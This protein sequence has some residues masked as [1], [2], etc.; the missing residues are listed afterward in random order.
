MSDF[1][2]DPVAIVA[3]ETDAERAQRDALEMIRRGFAPPAA[4]VEAP[5]EVMDPGPQPPPAQA[6]QAAQL[7]SAYRAGTLPNVAQP[8]SGQVVRGPDGREQGRIYPPGQLPPPHR[9]SEASINQR[10]GFPPPAAGSAPPP[11]AA[12]GASPRPMASTRAQRLASL[13]PDDMTDDE[14]REAGVA[15]DLGAAAQRLHGLAPRIQAAMRPAPP[16]PSLDAQTAMRTAAPPQP[17]QPSIGAAAARLEELGPRIQD[18]MPPPAAPLDGKTPSPDNAAKLQ[19]ILGGPKPAGN[20]APNYTGVD[21]VDGLRSA[22]HVI[23]SMLRGLSGNDPLPAPDSLGQQARERDS[24]TQLQKTQQGQQDARG[25]AEQREM[26]LRERAQAALE[27]D[28]SQRAQRLEQDSQTRNEIQQQR[29]AID[30]DLAEGRIDEMQ[31]RSAHQALNTQIL[32]DRYDPASEASGRARQAVEQQVELRGQARR[33]EDLNP[34]R[35]DGL[36][37]VE[38]ERVGQGVNSITTPRLPGR[39]GAGGGGGGGGRSVPQ[40]LV[41][42]PQGWTGTPEAWAALP[43]RERGRI[44][45]RLG[46]RPPDD[47]EE[48]GYDLVPGVRATIGGEPEARAFRTRYTQA[49]EAMDALGRLE[50]VARRA[51]PSARIDPTIAAEIAPDM[52]LLRGMAAQRQGSG[53]IN[54]GELPVINAAIPDP[55][56]LSGQLLGTLA[57]NAR[58]WRSSVVDGVLR[59]ADALGA[60]DIEAVRRGI[61]TRGGSRQGGAPRAQAAPQGNRVPMINPQG[62]RGTIDADRVEAAIAAGWT[63]P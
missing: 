19:R 41:D 36:A 23:G 29:A 45:G 58:V 34:T 35:L 4:P 59:H 49:G 21:T 24:Q 42:I 17:P 44:A 39:R 20:S 55:Q 40:G 38:A 31:H 54:P 26:S 60:S 15:P 28:R 63:R 10:F 47:D 8:G 48:E 5:P 33:G 53:V 12:G 43:E 52:L 51:G 50:A 9:E 27:S 25:R 30:A 61:M 37:A 56:S 11:P 22:L 2:L 1:Q 16:P 46:T 7:G 6:A 18:A 3:G 13:A 32:R 62:Q 57:T 14:R